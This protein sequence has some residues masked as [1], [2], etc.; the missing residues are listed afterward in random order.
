MINRVR[1]I[2]AKVLALVLVVVMGLLIANKA[3]YIHAHEMAD[4]TIVYHAHPFNKK[5]DS[6]PFKSHEHTDFEFWLLGQIGVLGLLT[7][8][9]LVLIL[10]VSGKTFSDYRIIFTKPDFVI[11]H[12]GRAPPIN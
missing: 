7:V 10:N 6:E 11:Y 3:A 1:K 9:F 8:L 4:G 2:T 12:H 5:N